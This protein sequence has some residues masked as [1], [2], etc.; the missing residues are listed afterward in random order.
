MQ[1]NEVSLLVDS[2]QG[3][4]QPSSTHWVSSCTEQVPG[5]SLPSRATAQSVRSTHKTAANS[6]PRA[7]LGH[8]WKEALQCHFPVTACKQGSAA[9][10]LWLCNGQYRLS[11]VP[12]TVLNLHL[13][14]L[15]KD[16]TIYSNNQIGAQ[17]SWLVP[18]HS[19]GFSQSAHQYLGMKTWKLCFLGCFNQIYN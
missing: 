9:P 19:G 13:S 2:S 8:V 5:G 12:S 3:F 11:A 4:S 17:W 7:G 10:Q 6:D 1:L 15:P 18:L 16:L 14:F